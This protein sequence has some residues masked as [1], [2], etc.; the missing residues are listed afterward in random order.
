ME[1]I[2]SIQEYCDKLPVEESPTLKA[3]ELD[4]EIS[5]LT[6]LANLDGFYSLFNVIEESS[7]TKAVFLVNLQK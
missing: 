1:E 5:F 4:K 7:T 2:A 6:T 3:L